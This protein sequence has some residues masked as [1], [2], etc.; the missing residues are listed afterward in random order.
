MLRKGRGSGLVM[1]G[2]R[3]PTRRGVPVETKARSGRTILMVFQEKMVNSS[4][5][6]VGQGGPGVDGPAG[7]AVSCVPRPL[8]R[9]AEAR[10]RGRPSRL[11]RACTGTGLRP[12][13]PGGHL[14]GRP[15]SA[16]Q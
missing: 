4:D 6:T 9:C 15:R 8:R 16:H 10:A 5:D 1:G 3:P 12:L 11:D 7:I 13:L 2:T 14:P